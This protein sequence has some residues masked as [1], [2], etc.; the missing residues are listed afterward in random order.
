M[1]ILLIDSLLL[2]VNVSMEM[3]VAG[4]MYPGGK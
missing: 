1:D 4:C 3:K 2:L